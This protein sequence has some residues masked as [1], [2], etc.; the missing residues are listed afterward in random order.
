[1][2]GIPDMNDQPADEIVGQLSDRSL[3]AAMLLAEGD[4]SRTRDGVTAVFQGAHQEAVLAKE[5]YAVEIQRRKR[6]GI[7]V[8]E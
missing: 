7:S 2:E 4:A 3:R 1:L 6:L 5:R 8:P